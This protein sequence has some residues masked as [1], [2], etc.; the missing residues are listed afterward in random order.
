M[1]AHS[2]SAAHV[3]WVSALASARICGDSSFELSGVWPGLGMRISLAT[4]QGSS[5]DDQFTQK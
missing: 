5:T 1:L 4:R 3:R 2:A